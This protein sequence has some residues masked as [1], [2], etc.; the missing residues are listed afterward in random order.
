VVG[1]FF[2]A[3]GGSNP[4]TEK[5]AVVGQP[6]VPPA[7]VGTLFSVDCQSATSCVAVGNFG[8][9][10]LSLVWNGSEW[11]TRPA[12]GIAGDDGQ[13]AGISCPSTSDGVA[14]G[15]A[16]DHRTYA[17]LAEQWNGANWAHGG[18]IAAQG[19]PLRRTR[20]PSDALCYYSSGSILSAI[21]CPSLTSCVAVGSNGTTGAPFV[22]TEDGVWTL[23]RAPGV[24][25][26]DVNWLGVSCWSP[27]GCMAVG[28]ANSR[29]PDAALAERWN[30]REWT[31]EGPLDVP[32]AYHGEPGGTQWPLTVSVRERLMSVG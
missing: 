26:K 1:I 12:V 21:S 19:T 15:E 24:P 18:L 28:W 4:V 25:G 23:G 20:C 8:S 32:S 16:F 17:P 29:G 9:G 10:P 30:G 7:G 5:Y 13:L 11:L 3:G 27:S 22:A 14:V 2:A 6:I 31:L